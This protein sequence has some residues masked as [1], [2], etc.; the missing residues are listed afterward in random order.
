MHR[1]SGSGR[2]IHQS[3][4]AGINHYFSTAK[5]A[6][7]EN[8]KYD[9]SIV[10]IPSIHLIQFPRNKNYEVCHSSITKTDWLGCYLSFRLQFHYRAINKPSYS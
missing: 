7:G 2:L 10:Q 8:L 5:Q 3:P 6:S 4:C 9:L 1:M